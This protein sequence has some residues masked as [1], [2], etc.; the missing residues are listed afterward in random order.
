MSKYVSLCWHPWRCNP[1][2]YID[3]RLMTPNG[4]PVQLTREGM[5]FVVRLGGREISRTIDNAATC[6]VLNSIEA[7][8]AI[9]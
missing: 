4:D 5:N 6:T 7:G 3:A 2:D 1:L 8:L 9:G